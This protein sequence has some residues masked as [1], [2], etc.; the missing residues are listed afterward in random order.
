M[1]SLITILVFY[2]VSSRLPMFRI[3]CERYEHY[4]PWHLRFPCFSFRQESVRPSQVRCARRRMDA[5]CKS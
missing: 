5:S 4:E 2:I 3:V 1:V